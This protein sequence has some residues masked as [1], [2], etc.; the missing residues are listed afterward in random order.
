ML[1]SG[2]EMIT[3]N[4]LLTKSFVTPGLVQK[5]MITTSLEQLFNGIQNERL[6]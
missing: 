6:M 1:N 2:R 5:T 4:D 3:Q